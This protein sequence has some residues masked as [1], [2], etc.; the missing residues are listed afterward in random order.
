MSVPKAITNWT[1]RYLISDTLTRSFRVV[2]L[3]R[4]FCLLLCC[5]GAFDLYWPCKG[6][7]IIH[8]PRD[9]RELIFLL[10]S[11][12]DFLTTTVPTP[13]PAPPCSRNCMPPLL[14]L[15]PHASCLRV[16]ES[17]TRRPF[18]RALLLLLLLLLLCVSQLPPALSLLSS[19]YIS[20]FLLAEKEG[21]KGGGDFVHGWTFVDGCTCCL[22]L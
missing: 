4:H 15:H 8:A 10:F 5:C 13:P 7:P 1:N 6:G 12:D 2:L 18:R 19:L 14:T 16:L 17:K 21:G 20:V 3:R 22:W 11:P 9:F